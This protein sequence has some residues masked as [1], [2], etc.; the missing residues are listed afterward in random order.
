[1]ELVTSRKPR[2]RVQSTQYARPSANRRIKIEYQPVFEWGPNC[3]AQDVIDFA[4]FFPKTDDAESGHSSPK[5]I[6]EDQGVG[7]V[8]QFPWPWP[9][10]AGAASRSPSH[11]DSV[12]S[13][14]ISIFRHCLGVGFKRHKIPPT[15]FLLF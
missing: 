3:S 11:S 6:G 9:C 1:M 8:E 5:H 12:F 14:H 4:T 10:D 15:A 13:V 2:T 7:K